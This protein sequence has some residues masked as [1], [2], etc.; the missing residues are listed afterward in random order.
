MATPASGAI[1]LND[2]HVEAGGTGVTNTTCSLSDADIR[3]IAN[4]AFQAQ[5]SF[6]EYYN[7]AQDWSYTMSV[8]HGT[9]VIPGQYIS[10]TILFRGYMTSTAIQNQQ[11]SGG[12][13]SQNDYSDSDYFGSSIIDS[14]HVQA[15]VPIAPNPGNETTTL[16]LNVFSGGLTNN[17]LAFKSV[18][19]NNNTYN[20]ADASFVQSNTSRAFSRWTWSLTSQTIPTTNINTASFFPFGTP[21]GSITITFRRSR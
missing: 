6:S 16:V 17:D 13:G 7:R 21:G 12:F 11:P 10:S 18:V 8:G 19:I 4:K 20:R 5:A 9:V 14:L 2:I 1:T 3:Q 15:A